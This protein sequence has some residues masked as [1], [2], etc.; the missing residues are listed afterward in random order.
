M[1][2]PCTLIPFSPAPLDGSMKRQHFLC[3]RRLMQIRLFLAATTSNSSA[4]S[5][6][7]VVF[8]ATGIS[9]GRQRKYQHHANR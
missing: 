3:F 6:I 2:L 1:D 7:T 8:A 5:S 4:I 9:E